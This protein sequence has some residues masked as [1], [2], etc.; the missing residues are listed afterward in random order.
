MKYVKFEI[1]DLALF[2]HWKPIFVTWF[3]Q[4]L[5]SILATNSPFSSSVTL[6]CNI[7]A[8]YLSKETVLYGK[9]NWNIKD[10]CIIKGK[11]YMVLHVH[12]HAHHLCA[13]ICLL[14][15][16]IIITISLP[17]YLFSTIYIDLGWQ[18]IARTTKIFVITPPPP[19]PI[20]HLVPIL[21]PQPRSVFSI[22]SELKIA[23]CC[24]IYSKL[25]IIKL[26]KTLFFSHPFPMLTSR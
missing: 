10:Y 17:L 5:S 13:C 4:I 22:F 21:C 20:T 9:E 11:G 14:K 25:R 15:G 23:H 18:D 16:N 12:A 1:L 2:S 24:H 26:S 8:P 3:G 19:P 6:L 7:S